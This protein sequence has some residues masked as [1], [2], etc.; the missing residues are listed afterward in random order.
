MKPLIIAVALILFSCVPVLADDQ[1]ERE[2][3]LKN[4]L[5]QIDLRGRSE[6]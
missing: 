5:W 2:L 1:Y 6:G 3:A 4:Q